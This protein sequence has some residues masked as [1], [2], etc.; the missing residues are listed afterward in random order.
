M[1]FEPKKFAQLLEKIQGDHCLLALSQIMENDKESN[2]NREALTSIRKRARTTKTSVVVPPPFDSM[3]NDTSFQTKPLVQQGCSTCGSHDSKKDEKE[4]EFES[5]KLQSFVKGK[6][7]FV[8]EL[9]AL[10]DSVPP[11]SY[12]SVSAVKGQTFS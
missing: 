1:E 12:Q 3:M 5:M 11:A 6:A 9:G 2:A 8:S 4:M 7:L 10:A